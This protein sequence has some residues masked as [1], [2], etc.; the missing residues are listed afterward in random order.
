M[1]YIFFLFLSLNLYSQNI[2]YLKSQD[3]VYLVLK[4]V[5]TP[6]GRTI[7]TKYNQIK[8]DR[9]IDLAFYNYWFS[10]LD[11]SHQ[12]IAI[13]TRIKNDNLITLKRKKFLKE[14]SANIVKVDFIDSI[15]LKKFF[16]DL[17]QVNRKS[18]VVYIIDEKSFKRR[19]VIMRKAFIVDVGFAEM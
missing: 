15:G 10:S 19:N 16:I 2:D 1:K 4:E 7:S 9:Y 18:K 12:T 8:L 5:T 13:T 11:K 17:L 6:I 14:K 3:T